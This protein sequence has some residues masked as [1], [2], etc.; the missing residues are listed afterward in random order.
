MAKELRINERI[1]A[2]RV[3]LIRGEEQ[4]GIV[5]RNDALRLAEESGFDLVEVAPTADPPVCR[6]LDYGKFKYEQSKR[7]KESRKGAKHSELREVRMR[8]KIDDHD[9]DFKARTARKLLADGDKVKVSVM[10]RAREIT[11]PEIGRELLDRFY[12]K[13]RDVSSMERNPA[14]EGRMLSIVV[15]PGVK[16]ERPPTASARP[17]ESAASTVSSSEA[18]EAAIEPDAETA[19][20]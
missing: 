10:F 3:R 2:P 16:R 7:E 6:I 14:M 18:T 9:I 17:A 5:P 20:A 15:T 1:L 13:I 8:V 4:L 12:E 19:T 11:H